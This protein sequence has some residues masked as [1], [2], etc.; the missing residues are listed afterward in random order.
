[1]Y[2]ELPTDTR[3]GH[4]YHMYEEIRAQPEVVA[5]SL[6][7][8]E[9]DGQAAEKM[10][11]AA[12]RVFV[13]GCGTS[14]HAAEAGA[15]MLRGFSRG[16]VDARAVNA[17]EPA[18]YDL[19]IGPRDLLIGVSHAGSTPMTCRALERARAAGAG[20]VT[21][22]GF[23]E[24]RAAELADRVVPTGYGDE[25]SWAHTASYTAALATMAGLANALGAERDRLDLS[26]L[27]E[28]MRES[29]ELEEMAHRLAA[30]VLAAERDRGPAHI[31]LAGGGANAA[32]AREGA[33]K[34]LETSYVVA[35]G[36]DLEQVLHGPL[37]AVGPETVAIVLAPNGRS[38]DRAVGLVQ[39]LFQI[40]AE[41]IVVT[42]EDAAGRFVEAHR[43]LG[44]AVPEVVSALP[45][46][47]PLQLFSY[48]LAL[49]KGLNPD[50]IHRDD[51]QYR[52]ARAAYE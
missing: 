16:E 7:L 5:R 43:L 29:L 49:G 40:G 22:T 35:A 48:F 20:T 14:F 8:A 12:R 15:W 9:R 47:V 32:T 6:T 3:H 30:G 26:P 17:F 31:V 2:A 45:T 46:V 36:W 11:R 44:P 33:L 18:T 50:L 27:P 51:E 10:I 24:S 25:R 28:V 39:A 21:I 19:G 23:P 13:A 42:D 41:P 4:P 38:T 34:L 1:M 52:A 37:A